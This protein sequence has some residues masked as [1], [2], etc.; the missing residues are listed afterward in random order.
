MKLMDGRFVDEDAVIE[1]AL[2][3]LHSVVL[4]RLNMDSEFDSLD[5]DERQALADDMC[6][7]F[8]ERMESAILRIEDE[9]KAL[10]YNELHRRQVEEDEQA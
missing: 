6:S 3:D 2:L 8:Q 9:M 5:R 7:L 4:R 10:A 1:A